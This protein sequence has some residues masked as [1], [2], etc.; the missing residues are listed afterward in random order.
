[1]RPTPGEFENYIYMPLALLMLA[2]ALRS[3]NASGDKLNEAGSKVRKG[4]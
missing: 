3:A 2:L 1:M 4:T